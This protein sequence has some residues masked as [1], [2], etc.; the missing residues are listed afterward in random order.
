[1]DGNCGGLAD[2]HKQ[3]AGPERTVVEA[4][5]DLEEPVITTDKT[6]GLPVIECK[7][8]APP[9]EEMTPE[10]IADILLAQEVEWIRALRK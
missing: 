9:G 8:A 6:T 7:H 10:R 1:M 2:S 4:Y 5:A 3:T